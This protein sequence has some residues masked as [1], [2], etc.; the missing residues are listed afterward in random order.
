M[1]FAQRKEIFTK[2]ISIQSPILNSASF[3]PLLCGCIKK[4]IYLKNDHA[5]LR[6][7]LLWRCVLLLLNWV[8][9]T[10]REF[11]NQLKQPGQ[12]MP[13]W[14]RRKHWDE[15]TDEYYADR[16]RDK[17]PATGLRIVTHLFAMAFAGAL[18]LAGVHFIA[19]KHMFEKTLTALAEPCGLLWLALIVLVYF[20]MLLRQGWPAFVSL[21]CLIFLSL[22][23]NSYVSNW[24][25]LQR[26][27]PYLNLGPEN[28]EVFD[29]VFVLGGGT[30]TRLDG[31][32]QLNWNGDRIATAARLYHGG[33][34]KNIICTGTQTFRSS[35]K[36]RHPREEAAELLEALMVPP[37]NIQQL[38]GN[39]TFEEMAN[40]K[41]WMDLTP[42]PGRVGILTSAWHLSRAMRLAD[43]AGVIADPI[44]ANFVSSEYV[45]SPHL[46][47]PSSGHLEITRAMV[48]EYLA[49]FVNR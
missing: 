3:Q 11:L 7:T 6:D 32:S 1:A 14:G 9:K 2:N 24:L 48:K 15:I 22:A 49:G 26:E 39:N 13:F 46:F 44:P 41:K 35:E 4:T 27:T 31:T 45:P 19:G 43:D 18:F 16:I 34:I 40:I 38:Q 21:G 8:I 20:C 33:K 36:D 12:T 37:G 28:L 5:G 25:A 30:G 17:K 47:I 29:T 42:N 23:G 10:T